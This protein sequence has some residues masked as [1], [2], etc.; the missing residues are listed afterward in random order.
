MYQSLPA[1][2]S[3][4]EPAGRTWRLD[5]QYRNRQ[6]PPSVGRT[7]TALLTFLILGGFLPDRDGANSPYFANQKLLSTNWPHEFGPSHLLPTNVVKFIRAMGVLVFSQRTVFH[8]SIGE[9]GII[10]VITFGI[11]CWMAETC[12]RIE[13]WRWSDAPIGYLCKHSLRAVNTT[14]AS[15]QRAPLPHGSAKRAHINYQPGVRD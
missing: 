11:E 2:A 5:R 3:R 1:V 6:S 8:S 9:I 4:K 15:E 10:G 13:G 7:A 12:S 14:E